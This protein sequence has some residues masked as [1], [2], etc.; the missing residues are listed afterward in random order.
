[1]EGDV[2][3]DGFYSSAVERAA[4]QGFNMQV[5]DPMADRIC[6]KRFIGILESRGISGLIIGPIKEAFPV[7]I[8]SYSKLTM[9][10]LGR[11]LPIPG[12][13]RVAVDQSQCVRLALKKCAD[14]G[15]KRIGF[16]VPELFY[17]GAWEDT[18]GP[19]L[20]WSTE[21]PHQHFENLPVFNFRKGTKE[22]FRKWLKSYNPE[23]LLTNIPERVLPL[24]SEYGVLVPDDLPVVLL[25]R[26]DFESSFAGVH[27]DFSGVGS[28]AADLVISNLLRNESGIPAHSVE[29]LLTGNWVDGS[30]FPVIKSKPTRIV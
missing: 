22:P 18:V 27:F 14:A 12:I 30:S 24:L 25:G 19:Y 15:Y 26:N 4:E 1:M 28:F 17:E 29:V 5:F 21:G 8:D 20:A 10:S 16:C 3:V 7:S 11:R 2:A 6:L 13:N 9:V 23:V